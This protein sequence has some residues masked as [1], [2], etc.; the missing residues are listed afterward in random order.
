MALATASKANNIDLFLFYIKQLTQIEANITLKANIYKLIYLQS[1]RLVEKQDLNRLKKTYKLVTSLEQRFGITAVDELE[2]YVNLAFD[3]F[4]LAIQQK[5]YT[6]F[7][8]SESQ[9]LL[10]N[11]T[12]KS[13]FKDIYG[14]LHYY[15]GFCAAEQGQI[16]TAKKYYEIAL[17]ALKNRT[18]EV[19]ITLYQQAFIAHQALK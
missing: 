5:Q 13:I 19:F 1:F 14:A 3:F 15:L 17:K 9:R 2:I 8:Y 16:V 7:V 6:A 11:K 4:T 18:D 12:I 10:K